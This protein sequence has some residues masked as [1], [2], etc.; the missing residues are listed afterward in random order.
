[1]LVHQCV[2][3]SRIDEAYTGAINRSLLQYLFRFVLSTFFSSSFVSLPTEGL[4]L[5]RALHQRQRL[6]C[7]QCSEV[8]QIYLNMSTVGQ[9]VLI[10]S[11]LDCMMW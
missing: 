5:S 7:E 11:C 4:T 1:M 10:L 3:F 6:D 8:S 9:Q 2:V